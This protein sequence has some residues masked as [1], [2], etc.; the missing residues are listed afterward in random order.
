MPATTTYLKDYFT[1][2]AKF[3]QQYGEKT[4]LLK[5]CGTFLEMYGL[6]QE[7]GSIGGSAIS[8]VAKITD[9]KVA[10]RSGSTN[11]KMIGFGLASRDKYVGKMMSAGYTVPIMPQVRSGSNSDHYLEMVAT[12]GTSF[13]DNESALS[14][15]TACLWIETLPSTLSSSSH[16]MILCGLSVVD[17][18]TGDS[19]MGEF[20]MEYRHQSA[21]FDEM[22]RFV[23]VYRPTETLIVHNLSNSHIED[24]IH[25]VGLS[26]R[27]IHIVSFNEP[28]HVEE[29]TKCQQQTYQERSLALH[30]PNRDMDVFFEPFRQ[31][32]S[33]TSSLCYLLNYLHNNNS[34]LTKE[35]GEPVIITNPDRLIT[36]NHSLV[37]LNIIEDG[38]HTGRNAAVVSSIDHCKTPMGSR[39][40]RKAI[41]SPTALSDQLSLEYNITE[42]ALASDSVVDDIREGLQDVRDFDKI[43]R[44]ISMETINPPMFCLLID[45]LR[46]VQKLSETLSV[47]PTFNAYYENKLSHTRP[48][49]SMCED[50]CSFIEQTLILDQ[51]NNADDAMNIHYI[52]RGVDTEHDTMKEALLDG[53]D[54]IESIRNY[55]DNQC[56]THEPN[57]RANTQL[58]RLEHTDKAGYSLQLTSRRAHLLKT[59]LAQNANG[60]TNE[61]SLQYRSTYLGT[62]K[63]FMLNVANITYDH[64]KSGKRMIRCPQIETL[65]KSASTSLE[66][67][68]AR[69]NHVY[70]LFVS[71]LSEKNLIDIIANVSEYTAMIDMIQNRAYVARKYNYCKPTLDLSCETSFIKCT[72]LR[73]PL[74]EKINKRETYVANDI[75][76]GSGVS[77]MLI[78]GTN[79][80][81][82]TSLM[83]SVGIAVIMAQAGFYVPCT[84]F[85]FKPYTQIF[86]RI[87][88]N[89]N[90]FKGLSSF[91]VEMS[92]FR[93][94]L[95]NADKNSLIL[96]DELCNGTES[97]SATAIFVTGIRHLHGKHCSFLFATHFHQ[98]VMLPEILEL[99]EQRL[100][101]KHMDVWYDSAKDELVYNRK[102]ADGSGKKNYGLEVCRA[103]DLPHDFLSE[104][105]AFRR[106]YNSDGEDTLAMRPSRYNASVIVDLCQECGE[107]AMETHHLQPQRDADSNGFIGHV[108]VHH[109][110][111]LQPLCKECHAKKTRDQT[112][113]RRV[114]TSNGYRLEAEEPSG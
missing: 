1:D 105:L 33:A 41:M 80:V 39:A 113:E 29:I 110:A 47:Q 22:E 73:H 104:A 71:S 24:I 79:A 42:F 97:N 15:H 8:D 93:T 59:S 84:S 89:D 68:R 56:A 90:L 20:D 13:I 86:T 50:I 101:L 83:R 3:V 69:V 53:N 67:L 109:P 30:Y 31:R 26:S 82:K 85:C 37:Q 36:A 103:L 78:Y 10:N 23:S 92:E 66:L 106:K 35:I 107:K 74:I 62:V 52:Q 55:F 91:A 100:Q 61:I 77:G 64:G 38:N 75:T 112:R 14:R 48:L 63:T 102:L 5:Q 34:R 11:H 87:V 9:L 94:I 108:P 49:S 54:I 99:L 114:K 111:N 57:R 96:G 7:D 51:C 45:S 2:N 65:F 58:V 70:K 40:L 76:I 19:A 21:T 98:I 6:V 12:P 43:K 95:S 25:F 28:N 18:F 17:V 60:D 81:G 32:L 72:G 4:I 88:G 27:K 46:H 44:M 16:P